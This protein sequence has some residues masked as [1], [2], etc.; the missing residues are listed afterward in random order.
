[1]NFPRFFRIAAPLVAALALLAPHHAAAQITNGK[2]PALPEPFSSKS[3]GNAPNPLKP[4]AGFLPT[5]PAGFK[6]NVFATGFNEPRFL[7]TAPNGDIFLSDSGAGKIYIL[8]DPQHPGGA[9]ERLRCAP[10]PQL[11]RRAPVDRKPESVGQIS[12]RDHLVSTAA[13]WWSN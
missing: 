3:V 7:I 11:L 1:M 4:P 9:Q 10:G 8:R 5:V 6:V 12:Q 2:S 13:A